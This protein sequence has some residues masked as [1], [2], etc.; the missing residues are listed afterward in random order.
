MTRV[1]QNA[2]ASRKPRGPK[3]MGPANGGYVGEGV[4]AVQVREATDRSSM[5]C[6]P[7]GEGVLR[8]FPPGKVR[9]RAGARPRGL[10]VEKV[11]GVIRE[12]DGH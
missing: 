2:V 3:W 12:P 8:T 1:R 7:L 10:E 6:P 5:P 4:P 9:R 11:K